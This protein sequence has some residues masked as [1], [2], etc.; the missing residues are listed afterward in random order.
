VHDSGASLRAAIV[1]VGVEC[2]IA[3]KLGR[4][5]PASQAPFTADNVAWRLTL[6]AG[7]RDRR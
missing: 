7:D 6:S 2:E 1:R 4:D 3:V 5:L